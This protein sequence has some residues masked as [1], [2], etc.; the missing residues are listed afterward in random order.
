MK[1]MSPTLKEFCR[2]QELMR[3]AYTDGRGY[4]RAVPVWFVVLEDR[5]CFGTDRAS[6]KWKAIEHDPRVGWVIDGGAKG[7]YKGASMC[8]AA[9]EVKDEGV[10]ARVHEAMGLKY[11]GSTDHPEFIKIFGEANDPETVYLR[12]KA[13]DG[14]FWEY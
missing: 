8:G 5:Y 13:E 6:A 11:F 4:P 12:L 9:E 7:E 1:E 10:R 3:V 2:Q 14:L